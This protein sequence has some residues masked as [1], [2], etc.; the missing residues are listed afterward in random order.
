[1]AIATLPIVL[2]VVLTE[3]AVGGS[4]L[5][6][7]V[8]RAGRAPSGFLKLVAFVDAGAIAAALAL[9]PTLPRGDVAE[10]AGIDTGP[11]GA[12]GQLLVVVTILVIIQLVTVFLPVRGLRIAAGILASLA[13]LATLGV[14]ALARPATFASDP[15]ATALAIGALPLGA[16]ALGGANAAMLLGHWYLVTPKLS[17]GPLRR[18]ALVV[19]TGVALQ[20]VVVGIVALR[21]DFSGT[22]ETGLA[23]ALALRIGVGLLMTFVVALAAWWTA[24]MNTQSSTGLLY[25]ALGCVFAGEVSARVIFFL[26]GVPI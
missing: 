10:T 2:S 3:L 20:M 23:V 4:F 7:F 12:Y 14:I 21:G 24:G 16:V 6:W 26:T 5:M 11:L 22:W 25:V 13:G 19:V 1:M 15:L 18:A 9:V 8:D 17:P